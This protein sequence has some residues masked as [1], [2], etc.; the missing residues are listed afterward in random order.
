MS[1]GELVGGVC[2]AGS[3]RRRA[4][5]TR[6]SAGLPDP[7]IQI[8]G[9][10]CCTGRGRCP[11]SLKLQRG[12][13]VLG[14]LVGAA[15]RDR[16]DRFVG[17]RTA[18]G[19]RDAERVELAFDVTGAD[20]DD[21]A[22][23]RERVERRERLRGLQRVLVR[24]DVHVRHHAGAARACRDERE[25]RD[26]VEPLRRHHLRRLARDRDVMAHRDVQEAGGRRRLPRRRPCRRRSNRLALP[27]HG[28][29]HA[30][31]PGPA[32]A[33]RTRARRR[34]RWKPS[35]PSRL[36]APSLAP[37]GGCAAIGAPLRPHYPGQTTDCSSLY[38]C[39]P[40]TPPSRPTPLY[41]MP[42]NGAL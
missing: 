20:A 40:N 18:L 39:R 15:P 10:G 31:A 16:V 8:G 13:G 22:A 35:R 7:P 17:D 11:T 3:N 42:P 12:P 30:R 26:R 9:R 24:R 38:A 5:A 34:G 25:R 41:F 33:A 4:R 19:E 37:R 21:R 29:P 27:L 14:P 28:R 32:A 6:R 36:M 23:V 2:P 1:S